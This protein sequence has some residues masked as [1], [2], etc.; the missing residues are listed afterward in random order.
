MSARSPWL[1]HR[2]FAHRGLWGRIFGP[3][4]NSL[5]AIAAARRARVGVELDVRLSADGEAMV[6][7]DAS[8][9]R[10][11]DAH[12]L[13]A[14]RTATELAG[15]SLLGGTEAIP[16]LQQA[17]AAAGPS[18]PL[19]IEL[20]TSEGED[21]R[22]EEAVLRALSRHRGPA[23]LMS[24]NPATLARLR[25]LGTDV[26]LG[27]VFDGWRVLTQAPR[28][29]LTTIGPEDLAVRPDFLACGLDALSVHGRPLANRLNAPLLAWTVRTES[30]LRSARGPAD[31]IIFEHIPAHLAAQG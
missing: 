14:A 7:H 1:T 2:P 5:A 6:F 23:A 25:A 29:L 9:E 21:G 16:T 12:G 18:T 4:E 11:T 13:L 22:L 3:P 24:F 27:L 19:L 15:V 17:L 10:M 20:K 26:P 31:Q 8:L 28:A 30:Q